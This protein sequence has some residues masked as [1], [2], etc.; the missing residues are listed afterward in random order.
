MD[1]RYARQ[2]TR[3]IAGAAGS[4]RLAVPKSGTRPTSDRVREAMFSSLTALDAV[5]GSRVLDLYAGSGAL[6]L[7]A[8]SRGAKTVVMVEKDAQ[9][10]RIAQANAKLVHAALSGVDSRNITVV[11]SSVLAFLG[12]CSDQFDLVFVDPPY[13]LGEDQLSEALTLLVTCLSAAAVVIVERSARSPE[14]G[15]PAELGEV[16]KK[17]YGE[18]TVWITQRSS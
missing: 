2:V 7:E 5:T 9:A 11:K 6:G 4:L 17:T 18:T 12:G 15:W 13:D 3:I 16:R 14:P 8:A 1:A 10:A